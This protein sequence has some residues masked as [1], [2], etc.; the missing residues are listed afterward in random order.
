LNKRNKVAW[1]KHRK[2]LKKLKEKT[3]AAPKAKP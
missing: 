2:R 3:Q 1:A